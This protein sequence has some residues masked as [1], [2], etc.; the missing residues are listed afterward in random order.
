MAT[1]RIVTTRT[2]SELRHALGL[3]AA[4]TA[5]ME[6]RSDLTAALVK[7]IAR[8]TST[9]EQ[10]ASRA[11]T[12]RTR[13]TAIANGNTRGISTDVMIRVLSATGY[14]A[15][16]KIVRRA[17][18]PGYRA[19]VEAKVKSGI[20]SAERHAYPAAEVREHFKSKTTQ[21]RERLR[22]N[23]QRNVAIVL[24][25]EHVRGIATQNA[26]DSSRRAVADPQPD[27]FR[28]VPE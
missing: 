14:T 24:E 18:A 10:I 25:A 4:D 26:L 9:H 20:D 28:R 21:R 27:D 7:T 16:L 13:V 3:G 22:K 11:G 15:R 19:F 2:A 12:S 1:K 17:D 23:Q 6:F 8:G 5:E